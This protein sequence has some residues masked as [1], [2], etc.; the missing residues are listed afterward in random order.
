[1][2]LV[3][4][5]HTTLVLVAD[6]DHVEVENIRSLVERD[7]DLRIVATASRREDAAELLRALGPDVAVI[8]INLLSY[9]D[10]PLHGWGPIDRRIRLVAVGRGEDPYVTSRLRAAGF[11]AYISDDRMAEELCETLRH[12]A[13]HAVETR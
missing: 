11:E 1:M 13:A 10:H 3:A 12:R 5:K 2:A 9:C 6:P 8:D 4:D 7:P